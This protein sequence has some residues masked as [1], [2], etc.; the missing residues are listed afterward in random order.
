MDSIYCIREELRKQKNAKEKAYRLTGILARRRYGFT[1][2][3]E[4]S[5]C[6]TYGITTITTDMD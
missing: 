5:L 4:N 1:G 3:R 2:R 6:R